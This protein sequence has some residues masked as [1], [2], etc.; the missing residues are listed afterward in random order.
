MADETPNKT[1]NKQYRQCPQCLREYQP[2]LYRQKPEL[3]VQ[4]EFPLALAWQREQLITG[5]CS[6]ICWKKY[7][8]M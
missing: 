7:L 8:G 4:V 2:A 3:S 1:P 5:L 6:D